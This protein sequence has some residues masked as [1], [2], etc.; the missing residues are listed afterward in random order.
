MVGQAGNSGN[1]T[2]PH[3][4]YHLQ[5]TASR[6]T[7]IGLSIQFINYYTDDIFTKFVQLLLL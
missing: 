4:H 3:L 5:T 1:S 2:E 7:G 6:S